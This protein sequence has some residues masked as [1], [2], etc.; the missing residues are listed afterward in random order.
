MDSKELSNFQKPTETHDTSVK[1]DTLRAFDEFKNKYR[2]NFIFDVINLILSFASCV[3][4]VVSTYYACAYHKNQTYLTYNIISRIYF[5][6]D[7][8]LNLLAS[9]RAKWKISDIIYIVIEVITIFPYFIIRII[10][11][12]EENY[13]RVEYVISSSIISIRIYRIEYLSKYIVSIIIYYIIVK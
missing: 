5:I 1:S 11:G 3:I 2:I 9:K 12:F 4:Y 7:F 6:I 13:S 8:L 10:S